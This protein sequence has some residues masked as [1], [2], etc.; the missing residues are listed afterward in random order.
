LCDS[1]VVL[2]PPLAVSAVSWPVPL[3]PESTVLRPS[4]S[5]SAVEV[6]AELA[7][8]LAVLAVPVPQLL[9]VATGADPSD[10]LPCAPAWRLPCRTRD[11]GTLVDPTEIR[12]STNI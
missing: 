11:G 7:P 8:L 5:V 6:P 3:F 4:L 2:L 1:P 9:G 12:A 10:A